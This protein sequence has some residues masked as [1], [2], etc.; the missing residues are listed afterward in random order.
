MGL[1]PKVGGVV[2]AEVVGDGV[3]DALH[4]PGEEGVGPGGFFGDECGF[5]GNGCLGDGGGTDEH[6]GIFAFVLSCNG[7]GNWTT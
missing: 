6:F 7:H 3:V 4:E 2:E 1:G 5:V